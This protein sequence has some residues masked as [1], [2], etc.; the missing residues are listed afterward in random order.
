[1]NFGRKRTPASYDKI[2]KPGPGSLVFVSDPQ[3]A[4]DKFADVRRNQDKRDE[5]GDTL[6]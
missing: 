3:A 2:R 4:L 1:M 5:H 6:M